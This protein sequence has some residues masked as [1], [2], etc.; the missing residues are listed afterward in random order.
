VFWKILKTY[1]LQA[2]LWALVL[3]LA[4]LELFFSLGAE[5]ERADILGHYQDKLPTTYY[6][7]RQEEIDYKEFRPHPYF[8]YQGKSEIKGRNNYGFTEKEDYP[9]QKKPKQFVLAILGGEV[10][11]TLVEHIKAF[12]LPAWEKSLGLGPGTL[13]VLN[14]S[15]SRA[16]QP[17]QFQ[18]A[19]Y[20]SGMFD[21]AINLEGLGEAY[22]SDYLNYPPQLP[23]NTSWLFEKRADIQKLYQDL[24]INRFW[25]A[26]L[27][28]LPTFVP[29]LGQSHLYHHFWKV[30]LPHLQR[31]HER[32]EQ[33]LSAKPPAPHLG[34][35]KGSAEEL[36]ERRLQIWTSSVKKQHMV[37]KAY[38][39]PSF[40]F[41]QPYPFLTGAKGLKGEERELLYSDPK[42][43]TQEHLYEKFKKAAL[44]LK[45]RGLPVFDLT[46]VFA[47]IKEQTFSDDQGGLTLLGKSLVSKAMRQRIRGYER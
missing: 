43:E 37:L 46:S 10:A 26:K 44:S 33:E 39:I 14:L 1:P 28:Y 17:Q 9:F 2:P 4:T 8:G 27:T 32:I 13:K 29:L 11:R 5:L 22:D 41:L 45:G 12:E 30:M 7:W 38:K 3:F 36:E 23:W 15:L 34:S 40:Y 25:Q 16:K 20:F 6:K 42:L 24:Q 31:Q 47:A 35:F 19:S 21:M 18:I